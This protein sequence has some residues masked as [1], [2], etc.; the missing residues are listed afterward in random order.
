MLYITI[1]TIDTIGLLNDAKLYKKYFKKYFKH[2]NKKYLIEIITNIKDINS[3]TNI[4]LYLEQILNTE[5][6]YNINILKIFMP[7]H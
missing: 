7:N 4:I 2:Y 3:R 6:L 1:I 5:I